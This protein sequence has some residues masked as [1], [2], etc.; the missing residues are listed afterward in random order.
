MLS[1]L[2]TPSKKGLAG[3]DANFPLVHR[4]IL[5]GGP[6]EKKLEPLILDSDRVSLQ[7]R[8]LVAGTSPGRG[9][10]MVKVPLETPEDAEKFLELVRVKW[11]SEGG[12][13]A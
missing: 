3:G 13:R 10:K 6:N 9:T 11:E 5:S 7:L 2:G 1:T 12:V 8:R 4:M